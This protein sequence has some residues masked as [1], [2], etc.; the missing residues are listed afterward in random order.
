M[1]TIDELIHDLNYCRVFTKLDLSQG[2]HQISS[3]KK[4]DISQPHNISDD[5]ICDSESDD[6]HEKH[7][8]AFFRRDCRR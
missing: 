2:Y 6:E 1:P 4:G 5:V 3:I 7:V 8:R